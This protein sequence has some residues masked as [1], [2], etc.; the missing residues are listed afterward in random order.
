LI[1]ILAAFRALIRVSINSEVRAL[2]YYYYVQIEEEIKIHSLSK[3]LREKAK[4]C[5]I[6]ILHT[7]LEEYVPE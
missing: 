2:L 1:S 5:K 3:K 7:F 6:Y 4:I